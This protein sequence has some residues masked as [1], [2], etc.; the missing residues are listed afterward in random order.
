MNCRYHKYLLLFCAFLIFSCSSDKDDSHDQGIPCETEDIDIGIID[1]D[2][3]SYDYLPYTGCEVI[4]YKNEQGD[5]VYFDTLYNKGFATKIFWRFDIQCESGAKNNYTFFSDQL[6]YSFKCDSLELNFIIGIGTENVSS[7]PLF[8]DEL[9]M[10][11]AAYSTDNR[12]DTIIKMDIV[13]S[14]KGNEVEIE[15]ELTR[16][17]KYEYY[18]EVVLLGKSFKNVYHRNRPAENL[19]TDLYYNKEFGIFAFRD[20]DD[21]LWVFDRFE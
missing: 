2:E 18:E 21:V 13:A 16:S 5:E 6:N 1:L 19:L 14:F 12:L 3:E 11:L 20:L 9:G 17:I 4:H 7:Q 15:E 8:F 10:L